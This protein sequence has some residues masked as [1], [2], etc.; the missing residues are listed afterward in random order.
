MLR[1][2]IDL[3]PFGEESESTAIGEM[4]IGNVK[5]LPGNYADYVYAYKDNHGVEESGMVHDFNRG[6]GVWELVKSCL[7]ESND[8]LS[9]DM[10]DYLSIRFKHVT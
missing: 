10:Q 5:M 7:G 8:I 6:A 4:I 9:Q 3:V 1:I 2:T